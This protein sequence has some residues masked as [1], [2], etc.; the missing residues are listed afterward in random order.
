MR[1][2]T[3]SIQ[4]LPAIRTSKRPQQTLSTKLDVNSCQAHLQAIAYQHAKKAKHRQWFVRPAFICHARPLGEVMTR[5][6]AF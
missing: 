2:T 3:P 6:P 1:D 5:K 4:G